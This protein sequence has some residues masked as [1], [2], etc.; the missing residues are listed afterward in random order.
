MTAITITLLAAVRY[1]HFRSLGVYREVQATI[2]QLWP[3]LSHEERE[4]MLVMLR[5]QTVPETRRDALGWGARMIPVS[6]MEA[7]DE[8]DS[9]ER[10][11]DALADKPPLAKA[12]RMLSERADCLEAFVFESEACAWALDNHGAYLGVRM[13]H[14]D[15]WQDEQGCAYR[16]FPPP[17]EDGALLDV[18]IEPIATAGSHGVVWTWRY[19][20]E[21]DFGAGM[22]RVGRP[23]VAPSLM[24]AVRLT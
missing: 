2:V 14:I 17:D 9:W 4:W 15:G 8:A 16:R 24:A 3:T 7:L 5:T 12:N 10:L 11:T 22:G 1:S 19:W 23:D 20:L 21:E 18:W 13:P 6:A